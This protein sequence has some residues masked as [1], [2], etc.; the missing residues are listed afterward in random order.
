MKLH[1]KRIINLQ[2]KL[3]LQE[4]EFPELKD[5]LTEEFYI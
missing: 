2:K 1:A 5:Y 3:G 4:S